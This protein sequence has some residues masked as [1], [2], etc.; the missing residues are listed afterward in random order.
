MVQTIPT[1]YPQGVTNSTSTQAMARLRIPDPTSYHQWLDDFDDYD[2]TMWVVTVIDTDNDTAVAETTLDEDGGVLEVSCEA[3]E[4]DA[5]WLQWSGD[6]AS[7][8]TEAWT[9]ESGKPMFFKARWKISDATDTGVVM[10][11]QITDVDPIAVSD[12]VFFFK[13]DTSTT[14]NLIVETSST[15]TSTTVATIADDTYVVTAFYYDGIDSIQVFLN[16]AHVGTSA[17]GNLPSTELA[18]SF[19]LINGAE[20]VETLSVDYIYIAKQR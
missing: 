18:I 3:D 13:A 19:G 6:D 9:F 4:L 14:C 20:G 8:V 7:G 10:G 16:D 15:E 2:V 12:G 11:L 17:V 1:R 5:T